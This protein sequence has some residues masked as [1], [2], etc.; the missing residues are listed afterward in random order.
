MKALESSTYFICRITTL[1]D[2]SGLSIRGYDLALIIE[3]ERLE[4][5]LNEFKEHFGGVLTITLLQRSG[6]GID[7]HEIDATRMREAVAIVR[8]LSR[9]GSDTAERAS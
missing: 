9:R 6:A 8:A 7:V 4:N 5:A 3:G 2:P 1:L